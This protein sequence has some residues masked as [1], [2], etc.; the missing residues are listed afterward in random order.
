MELRLFQAQR[1]RKWIKVLHQ[2][3]FSKSCNTKISSSTFCC[4]LLVLLWWLSLAAWLTQELPW[5][6]VRHTSGCVEVGHGSVT[7]SLYVVPCFFLLTLFPCSVHQ[8]PGIQQLCSALPFYRDV[9]ALASA[10]H[11]LNSLK[12]LANKLLPHIWVSSMYSS[13]RKAEWWN[14]TEMLCKAFR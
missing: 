3:D 4:M 13:D 8:K 14:L 11:G 9:S 2:M 10:D 12:L 5:G 6:S 7:F 1:S